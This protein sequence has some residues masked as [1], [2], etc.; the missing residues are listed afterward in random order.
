MIWMEHY[1]RVLAN[2]TLTTTTADLNLT[3]DTT[4]QFSFVSDNVDLVGAGLR[5][6][7]V[8]RGT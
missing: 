7:V 4:I 8:Y 3:A 5:C 2:P 6:M 1:R